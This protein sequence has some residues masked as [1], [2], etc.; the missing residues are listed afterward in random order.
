MLS[1]NLGPFALSTSNLV[2]L[3]AALVALTT[4]YLIGR[5]QQSGGIG[6]VLSD[7]MLLGLLAARIVFVAI[8]FDIY[9]HVPWSILDIRDGGFTPW[10]AIV[11]ALLV[12]A[13]HGS[14]REAL[15]KQLILGLAAGIV[16]WG[17]MFGFLRLLQ[18]PDL[19]KVALTTLT[20]ESMDLAALAGG[21]P[22]VV[23]LWATWCP[24]CR[25]EMP[26]LANAQKQ[27]ADMS[28]VFVNQGEYAQKVQN[29]LLASQLSLANVAL[30]PG[31]HLGREIGSMSLP[32]TLFYDASGHMVDTHVGAL[33]PA[34]LAAKLMR[35]R[36]PA[37]NSA[38]H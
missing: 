32:I 36:A 18:S 20:G 16:S 5:R 4:G 38:K 9:R 1:I 10:A 21:K 17:L 25:Q 22:M 12:A 13:W 27:E 8:W 30:D 6:H 2:L 26:V 37:D 24:P 34:S 33:S 19:P 14:R 11:T 35:L 31:S 23:N 3:L 15:R 28:F 7:M 29:Y